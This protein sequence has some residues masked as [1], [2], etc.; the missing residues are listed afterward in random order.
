MDRHALRAD[1]LPFDRLA[2]D[3]GI[4]YAPVPVRRISISRRIGMYIIRFSYDFLPVHRQ[5]AI[6]LIQ[7]EVE[8]ARAQG[9]Q[10]RLLIPLTRA[11]GGPSLHYEIEL[12]RLDLFDDFRS[13]GI[14]S[15]QATGDWMRQLSELLTAPPAVEIARVADHT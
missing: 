15:A 8:G 1:L 12:E 11:P 6:A 5:Q 2:V 13:T 4:A 3:G 9:L 7:R 10:A 14:G